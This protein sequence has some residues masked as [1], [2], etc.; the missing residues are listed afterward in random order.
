[1]RIPNRDLLVLLKNEYA[2]QK[3]I[4]QEVESINEMLL[5][6]ESPLQFCRVHELVVRNRI[7][8]KSKKILRAIRFTELRPFR[9]LL[10]K[11]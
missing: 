10:N 8:S 3:A 11:N 2:S 5:Q 1:M 6:A 4:E 7:T 9:F